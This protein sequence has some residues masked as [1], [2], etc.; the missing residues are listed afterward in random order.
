[1]GGGGISKTRTSL[2]TESTSTA[3]SASYKQNQYRPL[4]SSKPVQDGLLLDWEDYK[5]Q[6]RRRGSAD[7]VR[8]SFAVNVSQPLKNTHLIPDNIPIIIGSNQVSQLVSR[9]G[10]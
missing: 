9:D 4:A 8:D 10:I 1:M 6:K 2:T 5:R 3:A 7:R